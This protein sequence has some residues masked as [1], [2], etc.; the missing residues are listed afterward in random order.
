MAI[1]L[2]QKIALGGIATALTLG[3]LVYEESRYA[4]SSKTK[5]AV[6]DYIADDRAHQSV[7]Y[8]VSNGIV[9]TSPLWGSALLYGAFRRFRKKD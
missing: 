1:N 8:S 6:V 3:G 2:L 5:Q 7:P 9:F 4:Y